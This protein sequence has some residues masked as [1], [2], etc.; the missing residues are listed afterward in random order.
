MPSSRH[1]RQ[2]LTLAEMLVVLV[3]L[4]I[5]ALIAV[6]SL[7]PVAEQARYE[8]TKKSLVDIRKA[9]IGDPNIDTAV[10]G[11]VADTGRL[12]K[13]LLEL[14]A[15]P[16]DLPLFALRSAPTEYG[17]NTVPG[18]WRGP[19]LQLVAG[20]NDGWGKPLQGSDLAVTEFSVASPA[21]LRPESLPGYDADLTM[22]VGPSDWQA[23]MITGTLYQVDGTSG[24]RT[25]ITET[26][27]Q[28]VM[29]G[30]G[31]VASNGIAAS[32]TVPTGANYSFASNLAIGPRV[33]RVIKGTTP[34]SEPI[35]VNLRPGAT[36]IVDIVVTAAP[37]APP[38]TP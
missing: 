10:T 8:A 12:P 4:S 27:L 7:A 17:G 24:V 31:P 19:Y 25:P 14:L 30:P 16:E 9:I 1:S 36:H 21:S 2:A 5:V 32:P 34:R 20:L 26:G 38:A 13:N 28:V 6:Q 22:S 35:Y 37:T 23:A 29:L 3:I 15:Q 11:F 33:L 18:G